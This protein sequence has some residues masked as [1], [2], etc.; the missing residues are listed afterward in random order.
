MLG[1]YGAVGPWLPSFDAAAF[2]AAGRV[3]LH[4]L[5]GLAL[6]RPVA[7]EYPELVAASGTNALAML[8]AGLVL[9]FVVASAVLLRS[10]ACAPSRRAAACDRERSILAIVAVWLASTFAA[11]SFGGSMH[12]PGSDRHAYLLL[13]AV[14]AAAAVAWTRADGWLR[15][16]IGRRFRTADED[17]AGL[18][19]ARRIAASMA[20][21]WLAAS[22]G[23]SHAAMERWRDDRTLWPPAASGASASPRV[24][25]NFARILAADGRYADAASQLRR[26]IR[27]DGGD[28]LLRLSRAA[29]RCAEGRTAGARRDLHAALALGIDSTLVGDIAADCRPAR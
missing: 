21:L 19:A 20:A 6:L 10:A 17:A 9:V 12:E 11:V 13:P 1:A 24:R 28:P 29:V 8:F 16:E 4:Y 15:R 22:A 26:A 7:I 27:A 23:L 2:S 25:A 3:A 18:T 14:A 5:S